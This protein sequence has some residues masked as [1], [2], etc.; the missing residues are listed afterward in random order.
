MSFFQ[1]LSVFIERGGLTITVLFIAPSQLL[2][3]ASAGIQCGL[4]ATILQ[5]QY[6][7][8]AVATPQHEMSQSHPPPLQNQVLLSKNSL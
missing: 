1:T 4:H 2:I 8:S 7:Q 6:R 3:G 5:Q